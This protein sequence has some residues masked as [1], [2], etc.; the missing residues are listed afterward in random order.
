MITEKELLKDKTKIQEQVLQFENAI[1]VKQQ[2]LQQL[3]TQLIR[4]GGALAYIV[5]NL[6]PKE[7]EK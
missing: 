3:Q 4:F 1:A 7:S 2:E 6:K 5:D